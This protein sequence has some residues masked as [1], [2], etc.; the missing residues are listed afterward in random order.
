[1]TKQAHDKGFQK[2][3]RRR[4]DP[5]NAPTQPEALAKRLVR[6]GICPPSILELPSK[7]PVDTDPGVII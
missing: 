4:Q 6:A 3:R 7:R 1:M 5:T 2:A